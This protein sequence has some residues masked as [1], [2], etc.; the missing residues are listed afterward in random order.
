M[1]AY[2]NG[3][4]AAAV[5]DFWCGVT[6][7]AGQFGQPGAVPPVVLPNYALAGAVRDRKE[8]P[9]AG[10]TYLI[11]ASTAASVRDRLGLLRPPGA[12]AG[13]APTAQPK[14]APPK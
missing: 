5:R 13:G 4:E 12:P 2:Y 9:P 7:V 14:A 10:W 8:A 6:S 3:P 1:I 11:D